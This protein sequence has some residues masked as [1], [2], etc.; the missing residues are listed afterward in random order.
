MKRLP[1]E[2]IDYIFLLTDFETSTMKIFING[3]GLQKMDI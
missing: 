1:Q 3:I 2:L